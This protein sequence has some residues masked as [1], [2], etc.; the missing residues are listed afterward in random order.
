MEE[1]MMLKKLNFY[2]MIVLASTFFLAKL[3]EATEK[4]SISIYEEPPY[5]SVRNLQTEKEFEQFKQFQEFQKFQEF[6]KYQEF[7]KF[8]QKP[9]EVKFI[10]EPKKETQSI[11][12]ITESIRRMALE[13]MEIGKF[14]DSAKYLYNKLYKEKKEKWDDKIPYQLKTSYRNFLKDRKYDQASIVLLSAFLSG[15]DDGDLMSQINDYDYSQKFMN[16]LSEIINLKEQN[17]ENFSQ[18]G[19]EK[20]IKV[21]LEEMKN[22]LQRIY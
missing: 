13:Q 1:K 15:L 11:K 4:K 21:A 8:K 16:T 9:F 20:K 6:K 5:F 18:K 17:E 2:F 14:E 22:I 19:G 7:K 3:S 12:I 10:Q